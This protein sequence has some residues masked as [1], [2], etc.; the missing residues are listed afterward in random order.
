MP[1]ADCFPGAAAAQ[2]LTAVRFMAANAWCGFYLWVLKPGSL[3]AG[4]PF[5]VIPGPREVG[6]RELFLSKMSRP[7][8]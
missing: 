8:S 4:D 6:I 7:G 2:R 1:P 3:S 5:E